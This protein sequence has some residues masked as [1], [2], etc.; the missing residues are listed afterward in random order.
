MNIHEYQAKELFEKLRAKS[1]RMVAGTAEE[2]EAAANAIGGSGL[3]VKA[4]VHAGGRK[5]TLKMGSRASILR[6]LQ[7]RSRT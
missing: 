2:A 6:T 5:G 7:L 1:Q 4:Q 3:V